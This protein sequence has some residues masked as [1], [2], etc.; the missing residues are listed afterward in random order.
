L[1][2]VNYLSLEL[3]KGFEILEWK[4]GSRVKSL[5]RIDN[6][7]CFSFFVDLSLWSIDILA[8]ILCAAVELFVFGKYGF[9]GE[10]LVEHG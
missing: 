4:Y 2:G 3:K 5:V 9:R 1:A 7:V 8:L 6:S 10:L